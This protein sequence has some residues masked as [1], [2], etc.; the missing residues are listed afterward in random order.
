MATTNTV[1]QNSIPD[2]SIQEIIS[3][4]ENQEQIEAVSE[5][6]NELQP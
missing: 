1:N 2:E 3:E 6:V 5:I 4:T